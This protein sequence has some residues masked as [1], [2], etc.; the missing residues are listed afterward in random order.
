MPEELT[1]EQEMEEV[2][3]SLH[4]LKERYTQIQRD[5]QIQ[6]QLQERTA[7]VKQQLQRSPAPELR[8]ELKALQNRLDELELNLESRLFSWRS[9]QEPFWQIVR[10][11]GVGIVIGWF[12]AFATLQSPRPAPQP[13]TSPS[14][15]SQ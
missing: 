10:F 12:L 7:Q 14:Q 8:T 4:A 13:S 1:L 6:G 9:L 3:R 15:Q 2:E 5:Q 11:G